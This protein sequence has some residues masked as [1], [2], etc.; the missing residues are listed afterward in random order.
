M[1]SKETQITLFPIILFLLIWVS[2]FFEHQSILQVYAIFPF[3]THKII[4]EKSL[5]DDPKTLI[6]RLNPRPHRSQDTL[7]T[8]RA[9]SWSLFLL[10][11]VITSSVQQIKKIST[12]MRPT[13]PMNE[14][15]K[16]TSLQ[17]SPSNM[18]LSYSSL[19]RQRNLGNYFR[20]AWLKFN[21]DTSRSDTTE[22]SW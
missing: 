3:Y 21:F 13:N 9:T 7:K 15:V 16:S 19:S 4:T 5:K 18:V 20:L 8:N 10:Y 6:N 1:R 14:Q 11:F 2:K 12:T 22:P 17:L